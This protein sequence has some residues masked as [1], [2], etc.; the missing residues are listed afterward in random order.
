LNPAE[1]RRILEQSLAAPLLP[2]EVAELCERARLQEE[3]A[4]LLQSLPL[5][6][7]EPAWPPSCEEPA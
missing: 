2:E 3:S 5:D 1:V 6:E 4:V 7:E